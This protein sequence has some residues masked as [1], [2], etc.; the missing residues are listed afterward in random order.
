MKN[1]PKAENI[2]VIIISY[3]EA[4]NIPYSLENVMDWAGEVFV[5]DSYSTDNT[6]E[7]AEKAGA[8]VF[9]NKFENF[10][11]QRKHALEKLPITKE[12]VFFLDADEFLTDEL[13]AE[14]SEA[15]KS[16]EFDAYTFK[17]RFYWM[18]KWIKR[19]YYPV[20]LLR[21][22]RKSCVEWDGRPI[23]EHMICTTGKVGRLEHDFVDYNRKGLT[24]WIAKH[25]DYSTR[26]ALVLFEKDDEKYKFFGSQ[27]ERK[28]WIRKN[29][30][31]N[32]PPVIRPLFYFCYRYFIK[33]GILDGKEAFVYHFLHAYIYRTLI[34]FKYLEIKWNS[35]KKGK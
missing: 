19:G 15:V 4:P 26:E 29:I 9:Y 6:A 21:L 2:T 30:W 12:W 25:N 14:I 5:L 34:D 8:E 35:L 22:G 27:Y 17:R 10:Y 24:E 33:L 1:I 20:W 13:K 28:R 32:L 16:D 31:N 7:I 3:N 18:G 23:N 11:T